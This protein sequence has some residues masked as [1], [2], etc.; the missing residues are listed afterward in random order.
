MT[1]YYKSDKLTIN[2]IA[3]ASHLWGMYIVPE[4]QFSD[5]MNTYLMNIKSKCNFNYH[6]DY[7][8]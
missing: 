8:K 3:I 1:P 4:F 7:W 2:D 6:E 5:R